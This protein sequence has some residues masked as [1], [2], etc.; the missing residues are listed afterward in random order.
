VADLAAAATSVDQ[1]SEADS[2]L[3]RR[4]GLVHDLGRVAVPSGI[5]NKDR[6]LSV[7]EWE[8]VRLHAYYTER[9]LVRCDPLGELAE[10]ASSH[11]ERMDGSGY[12]KGIRAPSLSA[13]ARLLAAAD[14]FRAMTESRPYRG[15]LSAGAASRELERAC[16]EGSMDVP[17]VRAVL[18]AAG[19][20]H[21]P[22]RS[23]WPAGLT[24]REVEVLRLLAAGLSNKQIAGELTLSPKT[25]GHHIEHIYAKLEVA[26]RPGATL[27]AMEQGLV[28]A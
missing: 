10:V 15:A 12:H 18:E 9:I 11:H 16:A 27:F 22:G 14:A 19:E 23:A 21:K 20:S 7:E 25:V 4:A 28:G 2:K 5:W 1:A 13:E 26:T 6:P 17:C 8:R 3:L 24:D